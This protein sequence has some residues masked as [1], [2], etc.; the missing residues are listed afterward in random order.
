MA[1]AVARP[2]EGPPKLPWWSLH[3][4]GTR[5]VVSFVG[6]ALAAAV[7][8]AVVWLLSEGGDVGPAQRAG[9]AGLG[10]GLA[11]AVAL[12]GAVFAARGIV[13]PL[14]RLSE[15]ARA[16]GSGAS[17][18]RVGPVAGPGELAELAHAFDH[19]AASLE[20]HE[21][22]RR[23]M[24]SDMA[25]ELRTPVAILQAET[26]SLVDGVRAPT[27]ESLVSLHDESVRLGHMVADL[28]ALA[29]AD[30]AGHALNAAP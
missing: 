27:P 29:S 13:K 5:L 22:L 28:Q 18:V 15:A 21:H 12:L 16:V 19:M 20:Q 8:F 9:T 3:R 6:V 10:L 25:H 1:D 4:L 24:V 11:S 2:R 7:T 30:A 14:N 26:E 23:V 17:G